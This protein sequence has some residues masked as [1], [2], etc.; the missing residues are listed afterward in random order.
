MSYQQGYQQS[1][2]YG[3]PV[4]GQP[5]GQ[6]QQPFQQQVIVGNASQL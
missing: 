4:Y 5:Y 2:Q 6:P 1:P 3:Q